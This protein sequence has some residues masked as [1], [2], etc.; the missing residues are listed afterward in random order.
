M[1]SLKILHCNVQLGGDKTIS[2]L[3]LGGETKEVWQEM[4]EEKP[5]QEALEENTGYVGHDASMVIW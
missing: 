1:F 5:C 4:E 2:N 3:Q